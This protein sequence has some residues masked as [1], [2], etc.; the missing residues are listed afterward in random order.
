MLM[1]Y[2]DIA[3]FAQN[4]MW[5]NGQLSH[6]TA[7]CQFMLITIVLLFQCAFVAHDEGN[8]HFSM[9]FAE[10]L[11]CLRRRNNGHNWSP[12]IQIKSVLFSSN[13]V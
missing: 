3:A 13:S 6:F 9:I 2:D 5:F 8:T 1:T 4:E 11:I 7:D 10:I 12:L